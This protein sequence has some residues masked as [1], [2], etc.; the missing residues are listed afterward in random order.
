MSYTLHPEAEAE[1]MEAAV[2]LAEHASS[3]VAH[4][5][6]DEFESV[7]RIVEMHPNWAHRRTMD[8]APIRP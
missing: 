6:M 5:Y 7:A 8:F 3:R 4:A 2:Y 1:L